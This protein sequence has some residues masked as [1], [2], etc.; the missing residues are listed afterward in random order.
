MSLIH[1]EHSKKKRHIA[2][3]QLMTRA[4][5]AIAALK[6]CFMM[7]P[8]SVA[9]Y[10]EPG[11]H[12]FDLIVMDEA[13]QIRPEEALGAIGRARQLVVVGDPRQLPPTSFFDKNADEADDE[14]DVGLQQS[15]SILDAVLPLFAKRRLRWHYRSRHQSLIAFSNAHF[16]DSNLVLFPSPHGES[17]EFGLSFRRVAD[18]CFEDGVNTVEA[19]RVADFLAEQLLRRPAES[20]GVVSMNAKQAE[21]IEIA[22]EALAKNDPEV[23]AAVDRAMKG[24]EPLFL[25]NLERV[26][27][28]EREVIVISMTYGPL[29]P[30]GRTPQRFGPINSATGWRRLNVLLTRSKKR[31]QVFSSM[32]AAD[33]LESG[34]PSRGKSALR[35]FL[36]YCERGH[37]HMSQATGREPDSAF[38]VAVMRRLAD[39]GYTAEPQL[40]VGGFFLDLA[41]RDPDDPGRYLL[42][43]ECDG[44]TYHSAKSARDRDRLRQEILENLGWRVHRIW[45]TDW[46]RNAEAQMTAVLKSL[47]RERV[48]SGR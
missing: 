25:K 41:V 47:E 8:M 39:A 20:V 1:K 30:G 45:S 15:E 26:Q 17:E 10:L 24:S 16:Y 36:E 33:V 38:E 3:R 28:D 12:E 4:S 27:G 37:L 18:G 42:A 14:E 44:A 29:V 19:G 46:F 7:S 5:G 23:A 31:M 11:S 6:P 34:T 40:G 32:G 9:Q 48:R 35:N 43:I 22:L 21:A 2:I 13:S